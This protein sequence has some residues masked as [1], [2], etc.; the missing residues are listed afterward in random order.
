MRLSWPPSVPGVISTVAP[1]A[2]MPF[3]AIRYSRCFGSGATAARARAA[4]ATRTTRTERPRR[5]SEIR[6]NYRDGL[7]S[8][9][10]LVRRRLLDC[11]RLFLIAL[12]LQRLAEIADTFAQRRADL[13]QLP[14][15]ED[16]QRDDQN[17]NQLRGSQSKHAGVPP[18][19]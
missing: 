4:H 18:A 16:E 6:N 11:V 9:F 15:P 2:G 10:G 13:R 19:R 12:V 5:R 14:G 8:G 17:H 3:Q 7:R 1:A